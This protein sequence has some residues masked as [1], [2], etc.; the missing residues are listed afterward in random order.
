MENSEL[1]IRRRRKY[2]L[3]MSHH[4]HDQHFMSWPCSSSSCFW[5]SVIPALASFPQLSLLLNNA[6]WQRGQSFWSSANQTRLAFQLVDVTV[7]NSKIIRKLKKIHLRNHRQSCLS[8]RKFFF[9]YFSASSI[10]LLLAY[11]FSVCYAPFIW[12]LSRLTSN[13]SF[14]E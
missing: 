2:E 8:H 13:S 14:T 4:H 11:T 1:W 6:Y 9:V 3:A 12:Y 7:I 10:F 5:L